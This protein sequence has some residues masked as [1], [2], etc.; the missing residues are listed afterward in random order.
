MLWSIK[1]GCAAPLAS[2]PIIGQAVVES[3]R[4]D[5]T[6]LSLESQNKKTHGRCSLH[7]S[8]SCAFLYFASSYGSASTCPALTPSAR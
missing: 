8:S 3:L 6:Y 1:A 7:L 4:M 2:R 5:H